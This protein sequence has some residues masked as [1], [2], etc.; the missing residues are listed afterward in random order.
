MGALALSVRA[1]LFCDVLQFPGSVTRSVREDDDGAVGDDELEAPPIAQMQAFVS[2]VSSLLLLALAAT[3]SMCAKA[4]SI[5]ATN[6]QAAEGRRTPGLPPRSMSPR[7]AVP[8]H[9]DVLAAGPD[10]VAVRM[11]RVT[12]AS[13]G[14]LALLWPKALTLTGQMIVCNQPVAQKWVPDE[15]RQGCSA[16]DRRFSITKRR[17]H[18]RCCGELFCKTCWCVWRFLR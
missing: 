5:S 9:S 10:T 6:A 16:C 3:P 17:H 15:Q 8:V 13:L 2:T 18:C 1:V 7:L 12:M 14:Q 4:V 11:L